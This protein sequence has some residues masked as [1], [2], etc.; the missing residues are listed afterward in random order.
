MLLNDGQLMTE[1]QFLVI[2]KPA[3]V[4]IRSWTESIALSGHVLAANRAKQ[5]A[6]NA[7]DA[8]QAAEAAVS[9]LRQ[10]IEDAERK[11]EA[12]AGAP[13]QQAQ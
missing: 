2:M 12:F 4:C 8:K 13:E 6:S 1:T 3:I 5:Q 7:V 10:R 11:A 9:E